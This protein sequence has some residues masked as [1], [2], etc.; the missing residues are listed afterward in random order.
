MLI[1]IGADHGGYELKTRL[2]PVLKASNHTV[3]DFG[4]GSLDPEDDYPD[5]LIPLARAVANQEVR[6]AVAICGSGVG[7]CMV[8]N[9]VV[10]VRAALI[11][12]CYSARQ[13]VEDDDM[14]FICLGGR[15]VGFELACVLIDVFLNA[16]FR[17]EIRFVRRLDKIKA[18]EAYGPHCM[19]VK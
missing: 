7:A 8:A 2:L 1:G 12:D 18:L 3:I 5:I 14:N 6:R 11:T 15:V 13:G 19:P 9:K 10:N 4:A 17:G 16:E